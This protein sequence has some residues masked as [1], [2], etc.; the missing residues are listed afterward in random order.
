V[1]GRARGAAHRRRD[2][3]GQSSWDGVGVGRRFG[4]VGKIPGGAKGSRRR[5]PRQTSAPEHAP[6][7]R[8]RGCYERPG[9]AASPRIVVA[10]RARP[11][12]SALWPRGRTA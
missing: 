4:P 3:C 10:P 6:P 1:A 11:A 2:R 12:P 8:G 7:S 9:G 5:P